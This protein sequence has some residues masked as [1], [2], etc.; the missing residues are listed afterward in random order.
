MSGDSERPGDSFALETVGI[1]KLFGGV[2]AVDD[3]SISIPKKGMTA[4]IGPNGSGKS[5]LVNLLSGMLPLDGGIVIVD[6]VGLR[7]V[8]AH[9]TPDLGIT[10]TFQDVRLFNQISVWDNIMVVLTE[11]RLFPALKEREKPSHRDRARSV[12]EAVGMWEKRRSLAMDLSYG[13]RKLLEMGRAIA[14]DV[15]TYLLDEPFAG[16]FP[17]MLESVKDIMKS[18]R[19]Q[20]RTILFISHNMDIVRELSDHLIVLDSGRLLVEGEVEEVLSRPEVIEAYL[21]I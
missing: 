11:R 17:G 8:K 2:R 10:R 15:N 14:M 9:A 21:G 19:D 3:L 12:L 18:M 7:V 6:G 13:Q 20:G 1:T 5:T 16:L 4:V